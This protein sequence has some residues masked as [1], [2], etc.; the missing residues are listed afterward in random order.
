ML[1]RRPSS[2]RAQLR[3]S[4]CQVAPCLALIL[5]FPAGALARSVEVI[6]NPSESD[7]VIDRP[8]LRAIFTMRQRRWP[9]GTPVHVFVLPD[10]DEVTSEF[11]REELG[12]Y[13][14]VMR[15][16]WDRL[17]FTGTGLAPTIVGS[18]REMRERV[19][20]TPGA[21]GYVRSGDTSEI[22]RS[23]P[24]LIFATGPEEHHARRG[25]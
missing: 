13:Y 19:R 11:C 8:L 7:T 6:V 14:Y 16:T 18:A 25:S 22:R 15:T 21:I 17:V 10:S 9:D 23:L 3:A 2:K 4:L 12:T 5:C 24:K 20:S 1:N